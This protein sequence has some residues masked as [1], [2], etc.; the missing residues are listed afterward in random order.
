MKPWIAAALLVAGTAAAQ[1][2]TVPA[3]TI[4]AARQSAYALSAG[5]VAGMKGAIAA[6][7]HVKPW[8][9]AAGELEEWADLIPAMFPP[10]TESGHDTKARPEIWTDRT[11]FEKAAGNY[12]AAARQLAAAARADDKEAFAAAFKTT[13]QACGACHKNYRKKE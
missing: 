9:D 13:L 1:T 12:A 11:G 3:A 7:G 6:G 10:G 5:T 8:A 4:I 2:V